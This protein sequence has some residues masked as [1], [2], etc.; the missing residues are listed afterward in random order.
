MWVLNLIRNNEGED[1]V[2][3]KEMSNTED[4]TKQEQNTTLN[5]ENIKNLINEDFEN[6]NDTVVVNHYR[7]HWGKYVC[8]VV[9][10]GGGYL[11]HRL[12]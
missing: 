2:E 8:G 10:L 9:L 5:M 4:D 12:R 3:V 11:F 1:E 6:N 7:R